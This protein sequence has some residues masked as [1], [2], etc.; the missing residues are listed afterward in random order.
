LR[1][2]VFLGILV[3]AIGIVALGYAAY[4]LN[5]FLFVERL[6]ERER[7][8]LYAQ[9][10]GLPFILGILALIDGG[11][12]MGTK[13]IA[14]LIL[15]LVANVTWIYGTFKAYTLVQMVETE[16]TAYQLPFLLYTIA[17]FL[18]IFGV[19]INAIPKK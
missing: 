5:Q 3:I 7:I 1:G 14:S 2:R 16:I 17:V 10:V 12:I 11:I 8:P 19:V 9:Q 4:M 18:F 13:R 6:L 15:H